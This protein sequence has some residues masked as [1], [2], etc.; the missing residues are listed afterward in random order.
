[1]RAHTLFAI[2][3]YFVLVN[4]SIFFDYVPSFCKGRSLWFGASE[5]VLSM[6][7]VAGTVGVTSRLV[8]NR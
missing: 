7:L 8:M 4:F 5:K 2:S 6:E 3:P 1:M